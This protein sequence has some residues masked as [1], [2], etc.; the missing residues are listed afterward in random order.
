MQVFFL[1]FQAIEDSS[2][3][4]RLQKPSQF[5]LLHQTSRLR[6]ERYHLEIY[7]PNTL[8]DFVCMGMW[9]KHIN[10]SVVTLT[11]LK[12][13]FLLISVTCS[14]FSICLAPSLHWRTSYTNANTRST[15]C[16]WF[17]HPSNSP[18]A[19]HA[20]KWWRHCSQ[21]RLASCGVRRRRRGGGGVWFVALEA[22]ETTTVSSLGTTLTLRSSPKT[23]K[24]VDFHA[25]KNNC[26]KVQYQ[27]RTGPQNN[28]NQFLTFWHK[29]TV[30]EVFVP[31]RSG[32]CS[33]WRNNRSSCHR[34]VAEFRTLQKRPNCRIEPRDFR[35]REEV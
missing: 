3:W 10:R 21:M 1:S 17:I 7:L 23:P 12:L 24:T 32:C 19:K 27:G 20:S 16:T 4:V 18:S 31:G 5:S 15:Y 25:L 6:H 2:T 8:Q 26:T 22:P 35:A 14:K 30:G 11:L 28:F 33:T 29:L 13:S 34:S 9:L